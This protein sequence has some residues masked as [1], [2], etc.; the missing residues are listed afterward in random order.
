MLEIFKICILFFKVYI[1]AKN[2]FLNYNYNYSAPVID[3]MF[4]GDV[5]V[6]NSVLFKN[7]IHENK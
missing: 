5:S 7:V 1:S 6:T 4:T 3:K 2:D